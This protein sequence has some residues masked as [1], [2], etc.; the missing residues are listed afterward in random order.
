MVTKMVFQ[1]FW[2]VVIVTMLTPS[3]PLAEEIVGNS[4]DENCDGLVEVWGDVGQTNSEKR[5]C[6]D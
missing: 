6:R 3:D 5:R 1:G 4:V 2:M